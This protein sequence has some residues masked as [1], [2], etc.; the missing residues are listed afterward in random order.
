MY[1]SSIIQAIEQ[2]LISPY[3]LP[4][5]ISN[6]TDLSLL[7]Y[8]LYTTASKEYR[9]TVID[10][11]LKYKDKLLKEIRGLTY[12]ELIQMY[13][14]LDYYP[15]TMEVK[16]IYLTAINEYIDKIDK[17]LPCKVFF[18]MESFFHT[19]DCDNFLSLVSTPQKLFNRTSEEI[20][21]NDTLDFEADMIIT[22]GNSFMVP[23]KYKKNIFKFT[24]EIEKKVKDM[25]YIL[26]QI[27]FKINENTTFEIFTSFNIYHIIFIDNLGNW[28]RFGSTE[29]FDYVPVKKFYVK[30]KKI[31][32]VTIPKTLSLSQ[33]LEQVF[34]IKIGGKNE[35]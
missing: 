21:F 11:C 20:V 16:N 15:W 17:S 10:K 23:V 12:E 19:I 8:Y 5:L 26:Q 13:N 7:L 3:K 18:A 35:T 4:E 32:V 25:E 14:R 31:K 29:I 2:R 34:N 9:L 33:I 30:P 27:N 24:P 28:K 1:T 6:D 22:S